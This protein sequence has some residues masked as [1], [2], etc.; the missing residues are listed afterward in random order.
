MMKALCTAF[1]VFDT[2][3]ASCQGLQRWPWEH[4]FF[5]LVVAPLTTSVLLAHILLVPASVLCLVAPQSTAIWLSKYSFIYWS[6]LMGNT[7]KPQGPAN[8]VHHGI[9]HFL[10]PGYLLLFCGRASNGV[11]QNGRERKQAWGTRELPRYTILWSPLAIRVSVAYYLPNK[12][13]GTVEH[14]STTTLRNLTVLFW[15]SFV[16]RSFTTVWG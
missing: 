4:S 13:T 5:A 6:W 14:L 11:Q 9:L 12:V 1:S 8:M 3:F 10:W 15:Y 7:H 16:A 2:P